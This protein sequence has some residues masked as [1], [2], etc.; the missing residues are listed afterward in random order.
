MAPESNKTASFI[1]S[2]YVIFLFPRHF[3][4]AGGSGRESHSPKGELPPTEM[5]QTCGTREIKKTANKAELTETES[6][7]VVTRAWFVREIRRCW[8]N[9]R[10]FQL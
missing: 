10:N 7:V 6:R 2:L 5:M 9:G 8:S 1:H 3:Q 4:S